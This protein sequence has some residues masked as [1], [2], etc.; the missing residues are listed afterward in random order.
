MSHC[1]DTGTSRICV[2]SQSMLDDPDQ[3]YPSKLMV[4]VADGNISSVESEGR[5]GEKQALVMRQ[6]DSILLPT[7][8]VTDHSTIIIFDTD[9]YVVPIHRVQYLRKKL[10]GLALKSNTTN[11]YRLKKQNG[12]FPI[13][14]PELARKI[15]RGPTDRT[16]VA[17]ASSYY[18]TQHN[19]VME[20]IRFWHESLGHISKEDMLNMIQMKPSYKPVGLPKELSE[21]NIRQFFSTACEACKA[22]TLR[23]KPV[24][25]EPGTK[26][27]PG[28]CFAM[29]VMTFDDESIG[30]HR[31]AIV[32]LDVG[33]DKPFVFLVNNKANL[34]QFVDKVRRMYNGKGYKLQVLR[35]DAA[36]ITTATMEYC[37][38][39]GI[40]IRQPTP[41]EHAQLGPAEGLVHILSN[42]VNKLLYSVKHATQVYKKLWSLALLEAVRLRGMKSTK[43]N[44]GVP[45]DIAWGDKQ[46]DLNRV[47]HLPFGS[48]VLAWIPLP[49]QTKLSGRS[50]R[51][52]IVGPA[53][54]TKG[55]IL[56]LNLETN[57]IVARRSFTVLGP[58][59]HD[60]GD[61]YETVN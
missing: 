1:I 60:F 51:G 17:K 32:G 47:P 21:K 46:V 57:R 40:E 4:K 56:V 54:Y 35:A 48:K 12:I 23:Q 39:H 8:A 27:K 34:H 37:M 31:D 5:F 10:A 33:S 61:L 36:F 16:V 59:D 44:P 24:S 9:M 42:D 19:S 50:F 45:R 22:A 29:D 6:F 7:D 55:G 43:Q 49:L 14:S 41:Y 13:R 38:T 2:P 26:Y 15:V 18:T 20:Q 11:T 25:Q 3:C 58:Y 53:P 30:F 52:L 28:E